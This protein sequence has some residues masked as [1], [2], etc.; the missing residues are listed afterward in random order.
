M[1]GNQNW[2]QDKPLVLGSVS[3][4]VLQKEHELWNLIDSNPDLYKSWPDKYITLGKLPTHWTCGFLNY[5]YFPGASWG[6][7]E[8]TCKSPQYC[9]WH[10]AASKKKYPSCWKEELR[11]ISQSRAAAFPRKR[12]EK[13]TCRSEQERGNPS[14]TCPRAFPNSLKIPPWILQPCFFRALGY[15]AP[16]RSG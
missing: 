5:T 10:I 15:V 7:N 12:G 13:D 6:L 9:A 2:V 3:S 11:N 4:L 14:I 8:I 16:T 1:L